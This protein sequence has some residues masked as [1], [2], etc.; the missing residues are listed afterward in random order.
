MI[1]I[2]IA[3]LVIGVV[4]GIALSVAALMWFLVHVADGCPDV[5]GDP[6]KDAL[7]PT[8]PTITTIT[9]NR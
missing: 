2:D 4:L 6:E 9:A 8:V 3:S 5:N 1:A 7:T